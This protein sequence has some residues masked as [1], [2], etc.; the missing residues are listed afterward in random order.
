VRKYGR[1]HPQFPQTTDMVNFQARFFAET[2]QGLEQSRAALHVQHA[3]V[4]NDP[5]PVG[6]VSGSG[7]LPLN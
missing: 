4:F 5:S 6:I 7:E 3:S 1:K 2:L